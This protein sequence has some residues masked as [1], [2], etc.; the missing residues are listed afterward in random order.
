MI[1]AL[2]TMLMKFRCFQVK[3][4]DATPD[5]VGTEL[6]STLLSR[7]F[8][9]VFLAI[10]SRYVPFVADHML[11]CAAWLSSTQRCEPK[12]K[13]PSKQPSQTTICAATSS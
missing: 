6:W 1:L 4:K 7:L 12:S 3:L 13:S 11:M 8:H 9:E 10:E 2:S 5:A